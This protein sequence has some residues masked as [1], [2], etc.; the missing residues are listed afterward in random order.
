MPVKDIGGGITAI[1]V[2]IA[3][4]G[5][6]SATAGAARTALG[7]AIGT[8]VQAQDAE[9][10]AI[11]GLTS[12]AD[13]LPYFTGSGTASVADLTAFMRTLLDD[14]TD[15]AARATLDINLTHT[16]GGTSRSGSSGINYLSGFYKFGGSKWDTTGGP[17]AFGTANMPH[18][19]H[20]LIVLGASST[21][22]IITVTGTSMTDAGV[23]VGSDTQDIDTSGGSAHDYYETSKKFLGAVSFSLKSGTGVDVNYG[24]TKYWD[25]LNT[26]F[27]VV[28]L[29][30]EW[31]ANKTDTSFDLELLHHTA[32]GWTY[33]AAAEPDPPTA[34]AGMNADYVTEIN[35]TAG[36]AGVWKHTPLSVAVSGSASEGIIW[37]V[38]TGASASLEHVTLTVTM[39]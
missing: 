11:A 10:A 9:L 4:G 34:I 27:T 17:Q 25:R 6:S 29:E 15:V 26:D 31:L 39:T 36:E 8:D 28:G 37:R 14:A 12:A 21:D 2:T 1:P 35:N 22:M 18:A 23:R 24:L 33:N 13:K 19:S 38:T 32:T 7:L 3:Q 20:A 16:V 5:T 30:T